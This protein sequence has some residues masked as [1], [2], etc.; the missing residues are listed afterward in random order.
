METAMNEIPA[1]VQV[2]MDVIRS[3]SPQTSSDFVEKNPQR[4]LYE[5]AL[6]VMTKYLDSDGAE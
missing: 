6:K 3:L 2:A 5:S 4:V 1:R